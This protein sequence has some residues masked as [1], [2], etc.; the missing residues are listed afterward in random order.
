M[1]KGVVAM[2]LELTDVKYVGPALVKRLA[3]KGINSV[4]QLAA[5][6]VDELAAVPGVGAQTAPLI[7]H[8]AKA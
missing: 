4:E 2:A 8:N 1:R 3:E 6:P 5:M 7:L